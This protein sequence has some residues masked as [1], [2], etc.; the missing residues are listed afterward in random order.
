MILELASK[1]SRFS[2]FKCNI[3]KSVAFLYSKNDIWKKKATAFTIAL[4]TLKYLQINI[5]KEVKNF[6]S[7]NCNTLKENKTKQNKAKHTQTNGDIFH[8]NRENYYC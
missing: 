7:E 2:E 5:T 8:D 4:K 3:Q 6:Y 1:F